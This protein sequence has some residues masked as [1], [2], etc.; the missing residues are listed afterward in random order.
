MADCGNCGGKTHNA[1]LCPRCTNNLKTELL[2]LPWWIARLQE[3]ATGQVKLGDGGRR[4][5]PAGLARYTDP[6]NGDDNLAEDLKAGKFTLDKV[7]AIGGVNARAVRQLE[8]TRTTLTRILDDI[9]LSVTAYSTSTPELAC[10][11][12]GASSI[13]AAHQ[14]SGHWYDEITDLPEQIRKIINP[15][16][17]MRWLG[18]CP[19][20]DEKTR[21]TC[22]HELRAPEDAPEVFCRKCRQP[23]NPDRLRLLMM[24]D[25]EF[26]QLTVTEILDINRMSLPEEYRISERTFRYWRERGKLKPRAYNPN[27][28]PLYA[29]ADIR[30]LRTAGKA[31][32][33]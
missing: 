2:D 20:Y 23:H 9:D 15:P 28:E 27:G 21:Q 29:W 10:F 24:N 13:L 6:D 26:K 7:L 22:G 18:K 12:A 11:L 19:T 3:A 4:Q 5:P 33:A 1:Y 8:T 16:V 25:L 31:T 14:D 32:T 17:A 30:K